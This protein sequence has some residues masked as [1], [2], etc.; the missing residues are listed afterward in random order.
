MNSS[1]AKSLRA[2]L[3]VF[4]AQPSGG[5]TIREMHLGERFLQWERAA[6]LRSE[7]AFLCSDGSTDMWLVLCAWNSKTPNNFYIVV[8]DSAKQQIFAQI[9]ERV[10]SA[11]LPALQWRYKPR[12]QDS[13]NRQRVDHFSA[14][15][16]SAQVTVRLP[17]TTDELP[18]F[19]AKLFTLA[20]A[21]KRADSV[22]AVSV[23][24]VGEAAS[25]DD[26]FPE[27]KVVERVHKSRERNSKLIAEAK[28]R[29]I[30]AEGRIKC[31]C[32]KFD[33][34]E[35]YGEVGREFI[36]AHHTKPVS[37]LAEEGDVTLLAD[38]ALV[39][40]N[41]HRMLHRRRPWLQ[42]HDLSDLLRPAASE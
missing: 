5:Y 19:L 14:T 12:V 38:I 15:M 27:G 25:E 36:E 40:S 23:P 21:R 1:E 2:I 6:R 42:L 35:T 26:E 10:D 3:E 22:S 18:G 41:C 34:V 30:D 28:R 4:A 17:S 29:E 13:R 33:F 32:C 37:S 11:G 7:G 9:H 31:A 39:C 20:E 24:F 8:V 16:G